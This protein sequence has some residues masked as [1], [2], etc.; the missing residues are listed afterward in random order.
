MWLFVQTGLA[1]TTHT[2][3]GQRGLDQLRVLLDAGAGPSRI[4]IG[5]LDSRLDKANLE[6]HR[7][8]ARTGAYIQYD[9]VGHDYYSVVSN[10]QFPS[11]EERVAAI[12]QLLDWGL[13]DRILL[14]SDTC[15][16]RHLKAHGG[17]GYDHV[18]SRLVP[19]L[20]SAGIGRETINAMLI[21][22]PRQVLTGD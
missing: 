19:M 5:H 17:C 3:L 21:T 18:V 7:E 13:Q 1:I 10:M 15:R 20:A 14:S 2:T 22:N 12:C 6:Q 4:I 16:K 8:I 9:G 11:D